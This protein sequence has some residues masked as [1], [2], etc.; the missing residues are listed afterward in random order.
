MPPKKPAA[1]TAPMKPSVV[2][3]DQGSNPNLIR[4]LAGTRSPDSPQLLA[5]GWKTMVCCLLL[6]AATVLVYCPIHLNRFVEYDDQQYIYQNPHI[7]QGF[8]WNSIGWAF[9]TGHAANWHPVTWLSHML[10]WQLFGPQPAGP[11]LVNL[12]LHIANSLLLLLVFYRMTH[13]LWRSALVAGLFAL[14][15]LHVESVA[16]AA[17]RK[18]VLSGF[19]GLLTLLAY[20]AYVAKSQAMSQSKTPEK[21]RG[22]APGYISKLPAQLW[23]IVALFCFAL[24]LMSKPML[25]TW[26]CVMLLLDYWPLGRLSPGFSSA[27]VP[28][29]ENLRAPVRRLFVEKFPLFALTTLSC[30]VTLWVQKKAMLYYRDLSFGERTA[31]ALVACVRYLG[32]AFWPVHLTVFYPHPGHWPVALV[33]GALGLLLLVSAVALCHGVRRPYLIVGW[34]WFLGTLVPVLGLVQV[35]VQS[36]A[37][38]YTYLP[39]IGIFVAVVWLGAEWLESLRR[40]R[41]EA[42]VDSPAGSSFAGSG[43]AGVLCVLVLTA[44]ALRAHTQVFFWRDTES[45]FTHAVTIL[46]DNWL[47]HYKLA[48]VSLD[49]YQ[50]TQRSALRDQPVVVNTHGP[51]AIGGKSTSRDYLREVLDHCEAALRAHPRLVE[52]HVTYAKALTEAG[53]LDRARAELENAVRFGPDNPEARQDLAEILYRQ[54]HAAEAV[55]QYK[56]AVALRPDWEPVLNN[57]AWLLST[58]TD[59]AVRNGPEALRLAEHACALTRHTNLWFLN[60]LAAAYAETGDFTNAAAT[61]KQARELAEGLGQADLARTQSERVQLYQS[62]QALRVP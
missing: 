47:A 20:A 34:C 48:L 7:Q 16:W 55:I 53:Q 35:G 32:K 26:P 21:V 15:P 11:H 62:R 54:G 30:I 38:R 42:A 60:T 44:C 6:V 56:A 59:P 45:L 1:G 49:R 57:L 9:T 13:A 40:R 33:L 37:D 31:N 3:P 25:V 17:E 18:D 10:D 51:E 2:A 41:P 39:L 22:A 24:A 61:A 50:Q 46:P 43:M 14:H 28:G 27:S 52:V 5:S 29:F 23:Y 12:F 58:H 36:L 8:T 19:F 4:I